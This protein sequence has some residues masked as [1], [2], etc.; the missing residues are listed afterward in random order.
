MK[1]LRIVTGI[2]AA[3]AAFTMDNPSARGVEI[4]GHRGAAHDAPENTLTS[5]KTAWQQKADAVEL[6]LWLSRD[7][8][9]VVMHDGDTK[10][11]SGVQGKVAERTWEELQQIEVGNWK[12][13]KFK[14][15]RIP[16]LESILATIPAGKRAVLELKAGPELLPELQ[17]VIRT[18]GRKPAD[19]AIIAFNFETLRQSKE[20]FPDI[21]HYFLHS[22]KK[23]PK[24]GEFPQLSTLITQAKAAR[25]D[26]LDLHFDWPID[27]AFVSELRSA[28]MKLVVW[29]VNDAA[30]ARRLVDAGVDGITTDRPA[31]LRDQLRTR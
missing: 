5:M 29:T 28:G 21:P 26:G 2:T 18:S 9:L 3:C 10:R 20:R 31:W 13:P 7:G 22:Y 14:G 1:L 4:I 17:R 6:D 30:V 19:L 8:H 27:K 15:E 16:T 24:T 11:V 25:F 12:S 23:E